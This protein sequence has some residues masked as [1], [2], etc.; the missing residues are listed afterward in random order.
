MYIVDVQV[1]STGMEAIYA[2]THKK[3][4]PK[5]AKEENWVAVKLI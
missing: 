2:R 3:P 5:A 4:K 1:L